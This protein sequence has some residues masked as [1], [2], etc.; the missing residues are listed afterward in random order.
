MELNPG[1]EPEPTRYEGAVLPLTPVQHGERD[2]T[3]T[4]ILAG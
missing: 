3:R 4:R 2:G 1:L